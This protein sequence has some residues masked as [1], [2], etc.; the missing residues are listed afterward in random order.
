[1]PRLTPSE[2]QT[3]QTTPPSDTTATSRAEQLDHARQQ[4][5]QWRAARERSVRGQVHWLDTLPHRSSRKVFWSVF[6]G[7]PLFLYLLNLAGVVELG[8][9]SLSLKTL[10]ALY[11]VAWAATATWRA[12]VSLAST[13]VRR[14][15]IRRARNAGVEV[16]E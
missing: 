3:T 8:S 10:P 12:A 15:V 13:S 9:P 4:D 14:I 16:E 6:F 11:L 2:S 7:I 1:M 5:R